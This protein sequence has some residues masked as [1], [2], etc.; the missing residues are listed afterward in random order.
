MKHGQLFLILWLVI[1]VPAFA[2]ETS[3]NV[4]EQGAAKIGVPSANKDRAMGFLSDQKYRAEQERFEK[5]LQSNKT[6]ENYAG[7][8]ESLAMQNKVHDAEVVLREARAH[9][10]A[11]DAKVTAVIGYVCYLHAIMVPYVKYTLFMESS[12]VCCHRALSAD[13]HNQIALHTLEKVRSKRL[14]KAKEFEKNDELV[15]AQSEYE[16][17]LKEN[18]DD[19]EARAGMSKILALR[20][21]PDVLPSK[22]VVKRERSMF[23]G[24]FREIPART[25]VQ[26][27]FD[28][29]LNGDTS[30]PGDKFSARTLEPM[31]ERDGYVVFP[32]GAVIK[33]TVTRASE[34]MPEQP[35]SRRGIMQLRFDSIES[36]GMAPLPLAAEFVSHGGLIPRKRDGRIIPI[37]TSPNSTLPFTLLFPASKHGST[38]VRAGDQ[39]EL[40]FVD[41]LRIGL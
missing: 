28:T 4:I 27:V 18:N 11:K 12:V 21:E 31:T 8:A 17:L 34:W 1:A 35:N 6:A 7:L 41:G 25:V 16:C 20:E 36:K 13:P 30:K 39:F 14:E 22:S 5:L 10:F 9:D 33:G 3:E 37:G 32:A 24:G 38:E 19:V 2:L 26:I 15:L 40:D 29:S 23:S